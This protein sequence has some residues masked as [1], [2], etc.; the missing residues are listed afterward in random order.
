MR[1]AIILLNIFIVYILYN[2]KYDY[3]GSMHIEIY[4]TYKVITYR[5]MSLIL[6]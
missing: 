5:H 1:D 3:I 6:K 4:N 2:Y